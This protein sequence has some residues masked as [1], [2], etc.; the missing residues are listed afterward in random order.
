[1][2]GSVSLCQNIC[3]RLLQRH[4]TTRE[5]DLERPILARIGGRVF[6]P[7][8]FASPSLPPRALSGS[9]GLRDSPRLQVRA[10]CEPLRTNDTV[11]LTGQACPGEEAS[12]FITSPRS[13]CEATRGYPP[14]VAPRMVEAMTMSVRGPA[15]HERR[16]CLP[17]AGP[18]IRLRLAPS[19]Q[20][21]EHPMRRRH[22]RHSEGWRRLPPAAPTEIP[23]RA[24]SA[25]RDAV[26]A[27]RV[28]SVLQGTRRATRLRSSRFSPGG[29]APRHAA[30]PRG[31]SAIEGHAPFP[32]SHAPAS[33]E[34]S[35]R[36]G[37][38][39]QG[40]ELALSFLEPTAAPL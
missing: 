4:S 6:P 30:P 18:A 13:A 19:S 10:G 27:I 24:P 22:G 9:Q 35:T 37:S 25:K 33:D 3:C 2:E 21:A 14:T 12:K 7:A 38:M 26:A 5:H 40:L 23:V 31:G 1:M 34:A 8:L 16:A 15:S 11:S 39:G 28:L 20:F 29:S 36:N 32:P 17:N